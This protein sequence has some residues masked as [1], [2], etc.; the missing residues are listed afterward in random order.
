MK[1][2]LSLTLAF[3]LATILSARSN[4]EAGTPYRGWKKGEMDIHHI[5]TG[6]GEANFYIFPD[7]T[8]MLIDTGDH[9][10]SVPMTDPKPNLSR[11]AGEWVSRYILRTNPSGNKVDYLMVSHFHDDHMGSVTLDAPTTENRTPNYKLIG[12]AEVGEHIQFKHFI[13]RGYPEYNYPVPISDA[14][15]KNYRNFAEWHKQKYGAEQVPFEVGA[16][17]QIALQ[18]R[19]KKYAS[20]FSIRNLAANGEVWNGNGT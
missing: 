10:A 4:D 6:R 17:N 14:H 5:Y 11:R 18:K 7:G 13:D 8:S 9:L 12:I 16:L 19:P 15:I 1:R 20:L 2:I 3:S